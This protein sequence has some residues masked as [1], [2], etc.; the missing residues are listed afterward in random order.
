MSILGVKLS[1]L[2]ARLSDV[3]DFLLPFG[4]D[5]RLHWT[6]LSAFLIIGSCVYLAKRRTLSRDGYTGIQNFLVPTQ[7]YRTASSWLDV[8][9][10]FANKIFAPLNS[11]V[12]LTVFSGCA[13]GILSLASATPSAEDTGS[14]SL[15]PLILATLLSALATDLAYYFTHR[16]SHEVSWLWP[17]HKV[18]HSAEVLTPLTAKRNHPVFDLLLKAVTGLLGGTMAGIIFALTG[19]YELH[20]MLGL[21][22]F[23][24]LFNLM[25][26]ALRHSH[27]WLDYGPVLDRIF[28][29]PAQHQIHH[30]RAPRHH[31]RNYGL[32]FALWDWAFGTLYIPDGQEK[33]EFGIADSLGQAE[34]QPHNSLVDAYTVPFR[35]AASMLSVPRMSRQETGS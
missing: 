23:I 28:I 26:G 29:S 31:D 24:L 7:L 32:I 9:I 15:W 14:A 25:G 6:G 22:A 34:A 8:K 11:L 18:H 19:T 10:Y 5:S 1:D 20:A 16:A 21:G 27:I 4:T 2:T 35:E 17:F 12:F 30:S 3:W 33:L 13:A